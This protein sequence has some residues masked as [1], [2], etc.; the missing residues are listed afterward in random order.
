MC[1]PLHPLF[2]C[3]FESNT[4]RAER[5]AQRSTEDSV[6]MADAGT[7]TNDEVARSGRTGETTAYIIE[8]MLSR[9]RTM[10]CIMHISL[11]GDDTIY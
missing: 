10:D 6:R 3:F 5:A 8:N 4:T 11:L 9:E 1:H 7:V 2:L